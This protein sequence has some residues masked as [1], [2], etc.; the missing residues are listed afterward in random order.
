MADL[1]ILHHKI[2]GG[3][4]PES[5]GNPVLFILH[6]LFGTLDNWHNIARQLSGE[7]RVISVDQ[8]NHGKS[9]HSDDMDLELMAADLERLA[10]H[11]GIDT[12]HLLGHSMG[13]KVSLTFA[14]HYPG[15]IQKLII[16]DIAPKAYR[17][18]H[19]LIFEAMLR[20]P[21]AELES[22]QDAED[23]LSRD[24][25]QTGVRLFILKNIERRPEGGFRWKL[26]LDAIHRNYE[27]ILVSTEPPWPYG[28]EVLFIRGGRSH[29]ITEED[30]LQIPDL[31]PN[32]QFV[33]IPDA[34][35]WLH[36]DQPAAFIHHLEYF[37]NH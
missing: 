36:A 6:G 34:G 25:D 23:A 28:G 12:F 37:L 19:D 29:Y 31:F 1:Q 24:I 15:R 33:T 35:H 16:A 27:N 13:G 8:R 2:Y 11:L 7:F 22:R 3:N 32:V 10:T 18:G 30:M 5:A 20:L 21:L 14:Q 17:S 9:F 4:A 26:N